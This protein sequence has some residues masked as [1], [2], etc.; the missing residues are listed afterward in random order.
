VDIAAKSGE[1]NGLS[2]VAGSI[3]EM[4]RK[5]VLSLIADGGAQEGL[6]FPACLSCKPSAIGLLEGT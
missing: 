2:G 6:R 4:G 3:G 5:E 1:K